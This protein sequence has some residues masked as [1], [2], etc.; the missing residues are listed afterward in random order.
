MAETDGTVTTTGNLNPIT[1]TSSISSF[2]EVEQ[3][4]D[5]KS[6]VWHYFLRHVKG[7]SAMCKNSS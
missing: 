4:K 6:S 5:D 1:G 7:H 2:V 3:K